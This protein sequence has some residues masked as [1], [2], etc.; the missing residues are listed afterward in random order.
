[1]IKN[2]GSI[3]RAA[4]IIIGLGLLS[5]LM[6]VGSGWKWLGLV[7]LVPLLTALVGWCPAY[8]VLG[9]KTCRTENRR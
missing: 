3:D 2:I 5:T 6:F 1:M 8:G 9:V 4:R 7:G